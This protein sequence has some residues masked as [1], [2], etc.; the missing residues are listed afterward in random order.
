MAQIFSVPLLPATPQSMSIALSGV[1]YRVT[2]R[3]N[4]MSMLWHLD[5][6]DAD[7]NML[8]AGYPL[9]TGADLLEQFKYMGFVGQMYAVTDSDFVPPP[10]FFNLGTTGHLYYRI[11]T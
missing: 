8:F 11:G 5:M 4:R 6:A 1:T 9:V 2:L 10:T 7:G 3:W